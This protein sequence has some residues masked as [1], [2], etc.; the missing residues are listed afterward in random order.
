VKDK[1]LE[2][3]NPIARVPMAKPYRL[4]LKYP[5]YNKYVDQMFMLRYLMQVENI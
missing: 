3:V 5:N 4:V 2:V 1:E